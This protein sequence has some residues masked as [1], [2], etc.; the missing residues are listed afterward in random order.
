MVACLPLDPR[1][2]CSNPVE[3]DWVFKDAKYKTEATRMKKDL[4]E[5]VNVQPT[6]IEAL[7]GQKMNLQSPGGLA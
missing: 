7:R 5:L 1:F 2:A 6:I 4:R 3:D